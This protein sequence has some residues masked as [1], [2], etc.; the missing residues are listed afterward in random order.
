M[1]LTNTERT[2]A[3]VR[4]RTAALYLEQL[5]LTDMSNEEKD[6]SIRISLLA[7][8]L[9]KIRTIIPLN[10]REQIKLKKELKKIIQSRFNNYKNGTKS[11]GIVVQKPATLRF[12]YSLQLEN[13]AT[14]MSEQ[15]K[16]GRSIKCGGVS[17]PLNK[18][19]TVCA[20]LH[21]IAPRG[22][23]MENFV[24]DHW[25]EKEKFNAVMSR[26]IRFICNSE[27]DHYTE[28]RDGLTSTYIKQHF[29]DPATT[30]TQKKI[31]DY[32]MKHINIELYKSDLYGN[33]LVLRCQEC[34]KLSK[35]SST[36]PIPDKNRYLLLVDE[37]DDG[38]DDDNEDEDEE[39]SEEEDDDDDD[40]DDGL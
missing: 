27:D 38:E 1:E 14:V 18:T 5:D 35:P 37:D 19:G 25:F 40:E 36:H 6:D 28:G 29:C 4:L 8:D 22:L 39:G 17:S 32:V 31:M 23:H 11:K 3:I 7:G 15:M 33:N 21:V 2:R 20:W 16:N 24:L 9:Q 26:C 13:W 10:D 30:K 12:H 34:N